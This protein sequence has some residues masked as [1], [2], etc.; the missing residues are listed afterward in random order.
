MDG[1]YVDPNLIDEVEG[2]YSYTVTEK[3]PEET[4]RRFVDEQENKV[5]SKAGEVKDA[6][7]E[8]ASKAK[9][10]ISEKWYDSKE[11]I[12]DKT[13]R[14]KDS[15][16]EKTGRAKESIS[17]TSSTIG[18]KASSWMHGVAQT[19]GLEKKPT[20]L[21]GQLKETERETIKP[22]GSEFLPPPAVD[23]SRRNEESTWPSKEQVENTN[24]SLIHSLFGGGPHHKQ[25][26]HV[27]TIHS[28]GPM[29]D[30]S[31]DHV[32]STNSTISNESG[33]VGSH[34]VETHTHRGFFSGM[35]GG[36]KDVQMS[37][38]TEKLQKDAVKYDE[39]LKDSAKDIGRDQSNQN[40]TTKEGLV[41]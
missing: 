20:D 33:L 17:E 39:F 14:A 27:G 35:F 25:N 5:I 13:E 3:T 8:K 1:D 40:K 6:I 15:I 9:E 30:T 16:S 12:S 2:R 31:S 11:T 41:D 22:A 23:T 28:L 10:T 26:D 34:P 24:P 32:H 18:E 38:R 19:I 4:V 37:P 36:H 29:V 7:S 21:A